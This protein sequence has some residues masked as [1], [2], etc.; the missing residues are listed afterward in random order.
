MKRQIPLPLLATIQDGAG[1]RRVKIEDRGAALVLCALADASGAW[2]MSDDV[3]LSGSTLNRHTSKL[4]RRHGIKVETE[5]VQDGA[6]F[7]NRHRTG[8]DVSIVTDEKVEA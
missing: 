3:G 4:R 1:V 6:R 5:T 8:A 2:I 7:F